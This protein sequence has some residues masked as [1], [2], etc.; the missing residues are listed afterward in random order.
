MKRRFLPILGAALL[1]ATA[2]GSTSPTQT[3]TATHPDAVT[4]DMT[5]DVGSIDPSQFCCVLQEDVEQETF[6]TLTTYKPGTETVEPY[7]A[8]YSPNSNDTKFTFTIRKGAV[9]ADGTPITASDVAASLNRFTSCEPTGV[10]T[11]YGPYFSMI[12]GYKQWAAECKKGLPP[13]G[14]TGLSG[15]HVLGQNKLEIDLSSPTPYFLEMLTLPATGVLPASSFGPAPDYNLST[16]YPEASGPYEFKSYSANGQ[17]VLV[18]NPKWWGARYGLG[19]ATIKR[20]TFVQNVASQLA[21]ER[22]QRLDGSNDFFITENPVDS[23]SYLTIK[24]TPALKKLYHNFPENG[25]E[26]LKFNA[27]QFPFNT[28][29]AKLLREAVNLA[30]NRSQ[31]EKTISN[32]RAQVANQIIPPSIPGYNASLKPYPYDVQKARSLVKEWKA[33]NG[34]TGAIPIRY[35]YLLDTQDH[36]NLAD[37]IQTDLNAIGFN[38]TLKGYKGGSF[39]SYEEDPHNPWQVAWTAWYQDYPDAQDFVGLLN[40]ANDNAVD[41]GNY[42]NTAFDSLTDAANA[43]A[44]QATRVS[45]YQRAEASVYNDYGFVPLFYYWNDGLVAPF[46]TPKNPR[47]FL[48]PVMETEWQ[49][50]SVSK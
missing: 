2:C 8:T 40:S 38:V 27:T 14:V 22:F 29:D 15:I 36:I 45:D 4:V 20:L 21:L 1:L 9:F 50:I 49:Y 11:S 32:G 30:V 35:F 12:Q 42:T 16:H 6:A 25:L 17:I 28:K 46:F 24:S 18:R 43:T 47:Y 44:D 34:V 31:I 19:N 48:P 10:P 41:V 7:L 39:F 37:D 33:A 23:A 13:K 5:S 26:Y 3:A